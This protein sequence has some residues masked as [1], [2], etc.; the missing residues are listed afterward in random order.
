[1]SQ[2]HELFEESVMV[3]TMDSAREW[4]IDNKYT[5][6][7]ENWWQEKMERHKLLTSCFQEDMILNCIKSV[8]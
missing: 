2:Y 8:R 7:I 4:K 1:L 5:E 6:I 3:E